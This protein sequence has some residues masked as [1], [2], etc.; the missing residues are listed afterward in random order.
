M[1]NVRDV[2]FINYNHLA[3]LI[4]FHSERA[5]NNTAW[6]VSKYWVFSGPYFAAFGLNTV[7]SSNT[8]KYL[9]RKNSVFGHFSRGVRNSY[10]NVKQKLEKYAW[11]EVYLTNLHNLF[12]KLNNR[13]YYIFIRELT[14]LGKLVMFKSCDCQRKEILLDRIF[15]E[16]LIIY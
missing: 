1:K 7:F 3:V 11:S 4:R 10:L 2:I 16:P 8:G 6:K 5:W 13:F 15:D 14:S 9:N 12:E